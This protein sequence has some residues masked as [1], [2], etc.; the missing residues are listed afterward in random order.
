MRAVVYEEY[1]PPEVLQIAEVEK[2]TPEKNEVLIK[3]SATTVTAACML[4]RKGTPALGRL[5][6]GLRK[7][8]RPIPGIELAGEVESIGSEVT[9]FSIGDKVYGFAG[10][11]SG[12]YAEYACFPEDGSLA[13]KP[14]NLSYEQATAA[15]D[16]ATTALF[17]LRDKANIKEGQEVLIIGASGSIG[18]YAVQLAKLFGAKVTGVCSTA[19]MEL[20]KSLGAD[21]VVDYTKENFTE[22][23]DFYDIVFDTVG[24]SS[25]SQCN[26]SLK[27]NGC[28]LP[29]VGL[30]NSFLSRWTKIRG[31]K[32]VITGMSIHKNEALVFIKELIESG[33]IEVVIDRIYPLE[34]I[35]EAHRYVEQGHKVGS[36]VIS[37]Q[38]IDD[39]TETNT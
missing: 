9:R 16:G 17:F 33:K 23:G 21:K 12:T 1:G 7:P 4:M 8:K 32:R 39:R 3:V 25:F 36:V 5:I 24:K 10:L 31:G 15:V 30:A 20:V 6:L 11:N 35:V 38:N 13:A 28:Y 14:H 18:T 27:V 22:S 19:N 2:P 26:P 37:V 29:T 34:E